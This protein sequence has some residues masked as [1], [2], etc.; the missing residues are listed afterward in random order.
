MIPDA[1]PVND[2]IAIFVAGALTKFI[3]IKKIKGAI[4]PLT[5]LWVFFIFRQFIIFFHLENFEQALQMKIV[6]LFIQLP[7]LFGDDT[8]GYICSAFGTSK[9]KNFLFSS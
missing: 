8:N 9:V 2:L 5:F 7:A 1:W 3:V 4:L 6:P